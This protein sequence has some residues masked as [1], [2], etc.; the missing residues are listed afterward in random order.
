MDTFAKLQELAGKMLSAMMACDRAHDEFFEDYF[1]GDYPL[2]ADTPSPTASALQAALD[3]ENA[4]RAA[5]NAYGAQHGYEAYR[6]ADQ[7]P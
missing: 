7:R 2:S 5:F 3:R 6:V 1:S 4:A